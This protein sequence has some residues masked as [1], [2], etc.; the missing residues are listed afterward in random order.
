MLERVDMAKETLW[1]HWTKTS[2][3]CKLSEPS[4]KNML[5]LKTGQHLT[6]DVLDYRDQDYT[7][8]AVEEH[9]REIGSENFYVNE[10]I[11]SLDS[12]NLKLRVDSDFSTTKICHLHRIYDQFAFNEEF[13]QVINDAMESSFN[14]DEEGV[15]FLPGELKK[16]AYVQITDDKWNKARMNVWT[17][18][19][20]AKDEAG[21][22]FVETLI[23]EQDDDTGWFELWRGI[24]ISSDRIFAV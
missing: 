8:L 23:I 7:I 20:I 9:C 4:I 10:Y 11:L 17:F 14:L 16:P 22:G 19:R 1:E 12:N 24:E 13:L 2:K 18:K 21:Q 6:I 15:Q 3:E 5:G